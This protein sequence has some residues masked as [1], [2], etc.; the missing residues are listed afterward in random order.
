MLEN[1]KKH[2]LCDL[3]LRLGHLFVDDVGLWIEPVD[4]V[5]LAIICKWNRERIK[6]PFLQ[7]SGQKFE[8]IHRTIYGRKIE[9]I[10]RTI[11]E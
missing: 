7:N 3:A 6:L 8:T 4:I 10:H 1:V 11:H 9:T 2:P 5:R